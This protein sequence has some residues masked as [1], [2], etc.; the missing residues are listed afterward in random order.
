MRR[1]FKLIL[2]FVIVLLAG[3]LAFGQDDKV[4]YKDVVLDGKPAKLNVAT[5]EITFVNTKDKKPVK[6][7]DYVAKSEEAKIEATSN[8]KT[9]YYTV[10]DGETLLE[11][12][13][14]YNTTLTE[15]KRVNNLETTLVSKG[16][17]LRVRNFDVINTEPKVLTE[18]V[19]SEIH[20]EFHIVERGETLYS[21]AKR[22]VL[23]VNELKQQNG[24]MSNTIKIGQK[25]YLLKADLDE[26]HSDLSIWTVSKG[27]TLYSIAKKN[28]TTVEQIKDLNGLTSN[29][30]KIGQKL[31]LK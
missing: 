14:R 16:Q 28:A 23:T 31:Q 21:L 24:L 25:L 20:P 15:L 26:E 30:I 7:S 9:D 4:E 12:A 3:A 27:D 8:P 22:Y 18:P 19:Q 10:V 1:N 13:N 5:G 17:R 6:F 2:S 11:I 29:L